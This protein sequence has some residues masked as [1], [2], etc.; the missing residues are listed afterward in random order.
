MSGWSEHRTAKHFSE[1]I[2][3]AATL[4]K[5]VYLSAE[6]LQNLWPKG[7]RFTDIKMIKRIEWDPKMKIVQTQYKDASQ[8]YKV[9]FLPHFVMK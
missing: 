1:G 5:A 4:I 8:K 6:E 7:T 3:D 9:N 2:K